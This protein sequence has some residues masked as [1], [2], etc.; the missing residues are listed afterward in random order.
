MKL[1]F[2]YDVL[3]KC[4]QTDKCFL[5][6]IMTFGDYYCFINHVDDLFHNITVKSE[7]HTRF[8]TKWFANMLSC[9]L[10]CYHAFISP[11]VIFKIRKEKM[12][13]CKHAFVT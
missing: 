1:Q 13:I 2:K 4:M 3:Y 10:S 7:G 12:K 6:C 5:L 11:E 9:L 8:Y